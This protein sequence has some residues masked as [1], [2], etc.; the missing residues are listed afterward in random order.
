MADARNMTTRT[1]T[2]IIG[3]IANM[4]NITDL[5]SF[6]ERFYLDLIIEFHSQISAKRHVYFHLLCQIGF[7]NDADD[8]LGLPSG[9]RAALNKYAENKTTQEHNCFSHFFLR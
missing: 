3:Y 5:L 2:M 8:Q 6:F 7:R 9:S 1:N 4:S